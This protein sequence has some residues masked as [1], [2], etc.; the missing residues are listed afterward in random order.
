MF[1]DNKFLGRLQKKKKKKKKIIFHML[2]YLRREM[3][4]ILPHHFHHIYFIYQSSSIHFMYQSPTHSFRNSFPSHSFYRSHSIA[5][6]FTIFA[7]ARTTSYF[8]LI[9]SFIFLTNLSL[10]TRSIFR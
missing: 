2:I 7:F 8:N 10:E 3:L 1:R 5:F 6:T 4:H 9:V